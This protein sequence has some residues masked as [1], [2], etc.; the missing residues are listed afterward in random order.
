MDR[1]DI[2]FQGE[3]RAGQKN[4]TTR[5]WT[6]N[7]THPEEIKQQ[8]FEYAHIYGVICALMVRKLHCSALIYLKK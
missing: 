5:M 1:I 2:F 3:A 8:Q 6:P 7:S 4:T